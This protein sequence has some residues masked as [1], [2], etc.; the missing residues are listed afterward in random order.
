LGTDQIRPERR[1]L[2]RSGQF[3]SKPELARLELAAWTIAVLAARMFAFIAQH[4]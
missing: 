4:L 1:S 2:R 3:L